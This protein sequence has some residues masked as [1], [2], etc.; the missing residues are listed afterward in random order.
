[1]T[2]GEVVSVVKEEGVY[3]RQDGTLRVHKSRNKMKP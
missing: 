3:V 1:M 2:H